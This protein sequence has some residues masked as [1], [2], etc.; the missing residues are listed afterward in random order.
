V[1]AAI[2]YFATARDQESLLDY[3]GEPESVTL[4]PWPVLDPPRATLSRCQAL[5]SVHVTVVST[6]FG[7]PSLIRP[8]D[9]AMNESTKAGVFNRLNWQQLSPNDEA[10]LIDSNISPVLFWRPG[11]SDGSALRVSKIGSQADSMSAVSQEYERWVNRT[12]DWVRRRGTKVWGLQRRNARPDLDIALAVVS[13]IYA[14][15]DALA[16]LEAGVPGRS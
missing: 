11:H 10:G 8:G 9:A 4:S 7:P 1:V 13:T 2:H 12:M 6:T 5:A 14:L 16:A 3:L 15:P